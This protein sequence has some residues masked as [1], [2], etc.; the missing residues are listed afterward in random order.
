MNGLSSMNR[1][2][3]RGIGDYREALHEAVEPSSGPLRPI[4]PAAFP[5]ATAQS[6]TIN[7]LLTDILS[8]LKKQ[9]VA[10][11]PLIRSVA[12]TPAGQTLDWSQIGLM[13]RF[14]LRNLGPKS[15][16]I[17]CDMTGP[18]VDA[19]TSDLSVEVQANESYS[20]PLCRFFKIGCRCAA[21]GTG[22]VHAVAFQ[23]TAGNLG[24][25][26]V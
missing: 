2:E 11:T 24:G 6:A 13:D 21:G 18:A 25:S 12:V 17:A 10:R 3:Q 22:T 16:W 9:N 1:R 19:F 4:G 7:Q 26:T 8:E 23:A 5:I 15:V 20:I 14:L